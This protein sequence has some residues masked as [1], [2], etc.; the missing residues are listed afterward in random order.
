MA[1][2]TALVLGQ[3][4]ARLLSADGLM[5][6][7]ERFEIADWLRDAAAAVAVERG[8]TLAGLLPQDGA[9]DEA[10][11]AAVEARRQA[12][13][14]ELEALFE[15]M[16]PRARVEASLR[17]VLAAAWPALTGESDGFSLRLNVMPDEAR[18]HAALTQA[19]PESALF[20]VLYE[21]ALR[22]ATARVME[23]SEGWPLAWQVSEASVL[24]MLR[25]L[26]PRPWAAEQVADA[27]SHWVALL[28]AP[29]GALTLLLPVHEREQEISLRLRGAAMAADTYPFLIEHFIRPAVR[30]ALMGDKL[31]LPWGLSLDEADVV[32]AFEQVLP[33]E[34]LTAQQ[35]NIAEA[36]A[37]YLLGERIA[38]RIDVPIGQRRA[39]A[40]VALSGLIMRRL[41]EELPKLPVCRSLDAFRAQFEDI[42]A[43]LRCRL[44]GGLGGGALLMLDLHV[45]ARISQLLEARLPEVWSYTD[46]DLAR[47]L[48][49]E[50]WAW[51]RATR[52]ALVRGLVITDDD[53]RA[54]LPPWQRRYLDGAFAVARDGLLLSGEQVDMRAGALG[55][56]RRVLVAVR[57]GLRVSAWA[58]VGALL[59]LLA[60]A[61]WRAKPTAPGVTAR[62]WLPR[63]LGGLSLGVL[64]GAVWLDA[65]LEE[66]LAALGRSWSWAAPSA[67]LWELLWVMRAETVGP[68]YGAAAMLLLGALVVGVWAR[69][70]SRAQTL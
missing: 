38:L 57:W 26:A 50:A 12:A 30:Q 2:A 27:V 16:F 48:S 63:M 11:E 22:R 65:V 52:L 35:L 34:W 6:Y 15:A 44:R 43:P 42:N 33:D 58:G 8:L 32:G 37:A 21:Q 56:L 13:R 19:L 18:A 39:A 55:R 40:T 62:R 29:D 3:L 28:R 47:Q 67:R 5:A 24:G 7:V 17:Q 49:P 61:A 4:R 14:Q 31:W 69:R 66:A 41:H 20:E 25:D 9:G 51:V 10:H 60:L 23:A 64:A 1:A 54:Q 46:K 53:L 36:V 68:L 59:G 45:S 70:G